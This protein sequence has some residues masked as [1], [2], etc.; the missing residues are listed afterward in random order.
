MR[1]VPSVCDFFVISTGTS[2]TQVRA[3]ADHITHK[4]KE[5]G[6][7]LWHVEGEREGSW[8]LLDF[9]DVV[10][11]IFL[12]EMRRF[13]NLERLWSDCKQTGFGEGVK[14]AK[15]KAAARKIVKKKKTAARKA[16]H[17]RR[18]AAKRG[19]KR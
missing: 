17:S 14:P 15:K 2:T 7:K 11:H 9:G 18:K 19:R 10:A 5:K 13:Y 1:K 3:I 8:V 16:S 4:M 6:E 12:D